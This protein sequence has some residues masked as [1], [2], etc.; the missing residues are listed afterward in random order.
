M[1][2]LSSTMT[3]RQ[4]SCHCH[5][6]S[7]ACA[8]KKCTQLMPSFKSI[9]NQ[10]KLKYNNAIHV[11]SDNNRV[12]PQLIPY[13]SEDT[14]IITEHDLVYNQPSPNFCEL[15]K[16][17]GS[18]GTRGRVC[19]KNS[20]GSDNC[21]KLCCSRGYSEKTNYISVPCRCK[22]AYCCEVACETCQ[23]AEVTQFC[24]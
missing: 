7:G 23:K 20:T 8:V 21:N 10:I 14:Q 2:M 18:L 19:S 13:R 4:V 3:K 5:G 22:F 6:A 11:G 15:D 16:N 9:G 17:T 12:S 24:N 1:Q